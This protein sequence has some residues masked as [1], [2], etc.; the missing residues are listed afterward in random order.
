MYFF[1]CNEAPFAVLPSSKITKWEEGMSEDYHLG[2]AAR[3]AGRAR[4]K[5][6]QESLQVA[7]VEV[8]KPIETRMD[9]N[10]TKQPEVLPSP[11]PSNAKKKSKTK[12]KRPRDDLLDDNKKR[13]KATEKRATEKPSRGFE[14]LPEKKHNPPGNSETSSQENLKHA[15]ASLSSPS[16]TATRIECSSEDGEFYCRVFKNVE[17][18][19]D[20][21]FRTK[22]N[23]HQGG[24]HPSDL[25]NIGFVRLKSRKDSTF[26]DARDAIQNELVPDYLPASSEWKFFVKSLGPVSKKQEAGLGPILPFLQNTTNDDQMRTGTLDDPFQIVIV[27]SLLAMDNG[28]MEDTTTDRRKRTVA[29]ISKVE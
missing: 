25:V 26:R 10:H 23:E 15:I 22:P 24:E 8:E 5:L 13:G 1:G 6:F 19:Q 18:S 12:K 27:E 2:K 7:M 3:S 11:K 9:W 29:G 28:K 21:A 14:F 4:S 17:Q 20:G 16:G